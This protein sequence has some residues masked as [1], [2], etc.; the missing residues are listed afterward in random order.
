MLSNHKLLIISFIIAISL[1][2]CD[3]LQ[4]TAELQRLSQ[5][6]FDVN[7]VSGIRL[8]GVELRSGMKRS[9]LNAV[10]IMQLTNSVFNN[11]LPLRFDV[12]VKVDNPN[13]GT[14]ALSRMDYTV[15]LDGI[16]LLSSSFN[17]RYEIAPGGTAIVPVPIS[18]EL[19]QLMSG[20]S[21][22]AVANLGFKL[23]G[24][25]SKPVELVMKLKPYLNVAGKQI[26]YPN[27]LNINYIIK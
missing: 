27:T 18:V 20:Q 15:I 12:L 4:Q 22:D 11:N 21:A 6:K 26:Q 13:S 10:Q 19:F 5:C 16:E 17:Q 7:G 24:G 2:S 3:I 9:D 14:A 1:T 23:T 8:A 25:E